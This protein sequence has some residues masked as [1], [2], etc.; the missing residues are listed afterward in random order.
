MYEIDILDRD[1]IDLLM[2]DGRMPA[3]E[4]AR[5][6]G[7]N[8]SERMVR[9]R[10]SRLVQE[11]IIQI[12]AIPNP[13]SAGFSIV[14]DIWIEADA[15]SIQEIARKLTQ[16][17]FISYVAT[18]IG[19]RDISTQ[20]IARNPD[21]VYQILTEVIGKIPG[22]RKTTTSI[23]PHVLKDVYQWKFPPQEDK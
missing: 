11:N 12:S 9:Y 21:E 3:A 6:L 16:Y 23:V 15:D 4:I 14:A 20:I 7:E 18:S 10:I 2:E 22:V 19:E 13:K 1:I 5:R 17:S 8:I